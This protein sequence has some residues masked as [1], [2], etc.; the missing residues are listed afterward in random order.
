MVR[1]V[2][3]RPTVSVCVSRTVPRCHDW[4]PRTCRRDK[5]VVM[6]HHRVVDK[7]IGHHLEHV[8]ESY[9]LGVAV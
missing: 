9:L 8:E 5:L 3:S 1:R 6:A 4:H 7:R 2:L